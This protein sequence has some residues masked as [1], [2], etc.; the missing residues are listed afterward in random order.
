MDQLK[1]L[2]KAEA[3]RL[4]FS[5]IGVTVPRQTPHF[6]N[7]LEWI[8]E[9]KHADLDYL[10]KPYVIEGRRLPETLLEGARTVI[11]AGIHYLPQIQLKDF[12]DW[13]FS[14]RGW[15]AAYGCLPDYHKTLKEKFRILAKSIEENAGHKVKYKIFIDSGPVMEKDFALQAG[16]G[17]IGKNSLLITPQFGSYCMLGC[18]FLDLELP[19][20]APLDGDVCGSCE[21]CIQACPTHCINQ[22]RTI[23][24]ENC[25]SYQTIE[26]QFEIPES[27]G[28][29]LNGWVFGC[30]VCQMVCPENRKASAN[31]LNNNRLQNPIISQAI[32]LSEFVSINAEEYEKVFAG[33]PVTRVGYTRFQ[34]NILNSLANQS[35]NKSPN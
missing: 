29:K 28:G 11:V 26:N 1:D 34:R 20:D 6:N 5:F 27:I 30:D 32:K 23:Q 25:V 17:W 10:A 8:H 16:L 12:V 19:P 15:I 35:R 4:G 31:A 13:K 33:T 14:D 18:L 3:K 9:G 21:I 22:N 2:V 7:Y 24:T